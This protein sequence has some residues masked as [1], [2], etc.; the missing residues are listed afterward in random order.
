[1]EKKN[2]KSDRRPLA[3]GGKYD[4]EVGVQFVSEK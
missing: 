1:M 3:V 4:D 2:T